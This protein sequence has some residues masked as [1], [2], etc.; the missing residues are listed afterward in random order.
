M[1][2]DRIR[3]EASRHC[4]VLAAV[5]LAGACAC[6]AGYAAFM[7]AAETVLDLEVFADLEEEAQL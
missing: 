6:A 5:P 1:W 4:W 2:S 7:W 3:R